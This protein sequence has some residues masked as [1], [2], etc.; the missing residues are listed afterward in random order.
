MS[1]TIIHAG[2][3]GA[4]VAAALSAP[5]HPILTGGS[6]LTR[7]AHERA[8]T[9][10]TRRNGFSWPGT[11]DLVATGYPD[12]ERTAVMQVERRDTTYAL[13]SLQGPPGSLIRFRVAGDSAHVIWNTGTAVMVVD[14]R[15]SGNSL[16][17]EWESG[18]WSGSVRGSR[19]R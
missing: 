1:I 9:A 13:V 14:L 6:D 5:L 15:G 16:T 17:G 11:Y 18:D 12:G 2:A 10:M 3:L 4:I 8:A 19:R 7:A